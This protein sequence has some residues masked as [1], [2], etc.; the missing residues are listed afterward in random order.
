MVT[1]MTHGLSDFREKVCPP[2]PLTRVVES[3]E[4]ELF[5]EFVLNDGPIAHEG[6]EELFLIHVFVQTAHEKFP[7]LRTKSTVTQWVEFV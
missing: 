4:G 5:D 7:A 6:V 2:S 1:P 3:D